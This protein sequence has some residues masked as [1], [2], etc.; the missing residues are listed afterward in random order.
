MMQV[1]M[2]RDNMTLVTEMYDM[3][4]GSTYSCQDTKTEGSVIVCS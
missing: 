1:D 3:T 2:S 4:D